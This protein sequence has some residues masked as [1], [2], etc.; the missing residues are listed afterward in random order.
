MD[1]EFIQH[2]SPVL[3]ILIGNKE[4]RTAGRR[5]ASAGSGKPVGRSRAA[6]SAR[7]LR[8]ADRK[9]SDRKADGHGILNAGEPTLHIVVT[10]ESARGCGQN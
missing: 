2:V 5:E 3:R 4:Q 8:P 10:D 7:F 6:S 9:L 1:V